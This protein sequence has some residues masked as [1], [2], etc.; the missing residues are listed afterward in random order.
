MSTRMLFQNW[1]HEVA[2]CL[3]CFALAAC[4]GDGTVTS[5]QGGASSSG[6]SSGGTG[7]ASTTTMESSGGGGSGGSGGAGGMSTGGAAT[8]LDTYPL[9]AK[10]TEGG[11]YDAGA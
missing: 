7:G 2:V 10:F 3:A 9:M 1:T 8:F 4:G 6:Q 5:G 11:I